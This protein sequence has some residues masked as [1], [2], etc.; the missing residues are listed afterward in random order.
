[1]AGQ[2]LV[3]PNRLPSPQTMDPEERLFKHELRPAW[4]VG[5]W[6]RE[7]QNRRRLR[8]EDGEMRSFRR[9]Y[10]H[11]LQ[12]VD[13]SEI[14]LD[15]VYQRIASEHELLAAEAA[16]AKPLKPP[17]MTFEQQ[18]QVFRE[19]YP[20]G[21]ADEDYLDAHRHPLEGRTS[22]K[23]QVEGAIAA[24]AER[25][26][27]EVMQAALDEGNIEELHESVLSVLRSSSIMKPTDIAPLTKLSVDDQKLYVEALFAILH[28][29]GRQ[30]E[31]F[32]HWIRVLRQLT[33]SELGW[34]I[35][36][37]LMALKD[38]EQH[39]MVKP[40]VFQLQARSLAPS[41]RLKKE[42]T[43]RGYRVGRRIALAT[44]KALREADLN[45]TDFFDVSNFIW[46]TLR[47]K[48]RKVLE[49]LTEK[50]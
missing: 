42:A 11:L 43:R 20:A 21:F 16:E 37:A 35:V 14:D 48:G 15:E 27:A 26:S 46:E 24:A 17:V 6:V 34:P 3:L 45:P 38:P 1:M 40:R 19:L 10:Y 44:Q 5:L 49:G 31:R 22:R 9:G 7:E 39:V 30:R 32:D 36:T 4:G 25:L 12:P 28:G 13:G 33:K 8:F 18:V 47:P 29:D 41:E 23:S 50:S 2:E